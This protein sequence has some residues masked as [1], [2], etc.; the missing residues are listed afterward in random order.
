MPCIHKGW[1]GDVGP[2]KKGVSRAHDEDVA[3][4]C[5]T[6]VGPRGRPNASAGIYLH[7]PGKPCPRRR[8]CN[9]VPLGGPSDP[10]LT[11]WER[12]RKS[13]PIKASNSG[14]RPAPRG[15]IAKERRHPRVGGR[16][17]LS[18]AKRH[19]HFWQAPPAPHPVSLLGGRSIG[20]GTFP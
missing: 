1:G 10:R 6:R 9:R 4:S 18:L 14:T 15:G 20:G 5:S 13:A 19:P 7:R 8:L 17:P 2:P 16:E 11:R 3:P 12:T